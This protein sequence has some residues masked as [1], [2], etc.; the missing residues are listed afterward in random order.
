MTNAWKYQHYFEFDSVKTEKSISI[1]GALYM[2][3]KLLSMVK[4][5]TQRNLP[6]TAEC[7]ETYLLISQ[8]KSS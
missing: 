6:N 5:V 4:N 2:G 7:D 8:F 1:L 3:R